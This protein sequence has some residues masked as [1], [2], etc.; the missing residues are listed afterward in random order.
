MHTH[1]RE[2]AGELAYARHRP[3]ETRLYRLVE[4]HYPTFV[5]HLAEQGKS[6]PVYI[7]KEFEAYLKC[8]RLEHGFLRVKCESCHFE[9][10]VAFSCKR[11]GFCPSCG[12][13]R[14][15]ET[16]ALLAD[17]VLRGPAAG[18]LL[19]DEQRHVVADERAEQ[20]HVAL[21]QRARVGG[22]ARADLELLPVPAHR[23][24][25]G[26]TATALISISAPSR[27][28]PATI[29][30]VAVVA[31]FLMNSRRTAAVPL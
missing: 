26:I 14:M 23:G 21:G 10:L 8:G 18:E 27:S 20:R 6:L 19:V 12:A 30:P 24:V 15:A 17:E 28:S 16:A 9:R 5:A 13:R 1:G 22:V 4:Q 31:G 11:R 7:E 25:S 29:T 3:E 2:A